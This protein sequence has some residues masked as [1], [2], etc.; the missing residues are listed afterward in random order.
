MVGFVGRKYTLD[1]SWC[2][3]PYALLVYIFSDRFAIQRGERFVRTMNP[4]SLL[5][6][7]GD[8]DRSERVELKDLDQ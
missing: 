2:F 7:R 5:I 4:I 8:F 1:Y 6:S 3:D